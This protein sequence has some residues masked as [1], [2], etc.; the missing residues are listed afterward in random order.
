L[1]KYYT[2]L[3]PNNV[4]A[5]YIPAL[6]KIDAGRQMLPEETGIPQSLV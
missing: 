3:N 1:I 5:K 4:L 6:N 2:T